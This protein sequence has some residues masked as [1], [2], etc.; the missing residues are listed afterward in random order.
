MPV[1]QLSPAL[2]LGMALN[3]WGFLAEFLASWRSRWGLYDDLLCLSL[4]LLTPAQTGT[5]GTIPSHD[6]ASSPAE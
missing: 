5:L 6:W 4:F 3:I 1:G 2:Q